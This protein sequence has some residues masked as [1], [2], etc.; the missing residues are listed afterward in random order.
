MNRNGHN[1][2]IYL[3]APLG[4]THEGRQ[5]VLRE[6]GF[7]CKCDLCTSSPKEIKNS[8][9]RRDRIH[10]I[11]NLL[12][13]GEGLTSK[14]ISRLAEEWMK[15]VD[16]ES[17]WPQKTVYYEVIARAYFEEAKDFDKAEEYVEMCEE[18]WIDYGGVKHD[19]LEGVKQLRHDF[20]MA[21]L[22][23]EALEEA[24]R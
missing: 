1:N 4:L 17:L 20:E 19:N 12:G 6:W 23:A 5:N 8:D 16:L 9:Q 13:K 24:G 14:T 10:T 2:N 21:K 22:V 18:L 3:D 15:L 11:H 7:E